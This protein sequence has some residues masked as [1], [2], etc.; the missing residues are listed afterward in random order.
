MNLHRFFMFPTKYNG[1]PPLP[2]F[3]S[4]KLNGIFAAYVPGRGFFTKKGV[5]WAPEVL[6]H[7]AQPPVGFPVVGEL[8][9]PEMSLQEI[10]SETSVIR[11]SSGGSRVQF[12][13]HDVM[14]QGIAADRVKT[15]TRLGE[16]KHENWG[17]LEHMLIKDIDDYNRHVQLFAALDAEGVVLLPAMSPYTPGKSGNSLAVKFWKTDNFAIVDYK[18]GVGKC[19]NVLA[20]LVCKTAS[21]ALFEVGTFRFPFEE[22]LRLLEQRPLPAKAEVRYLNL[23]DTGIPLNTSVIAIMEGE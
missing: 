22:R 8:Y 11:K 6:A 4:P 12:W 5:Q 9:H 19:E 17:F 14:T 23:S 21:G 20:A 3:L 16:E 13:P 7:I 10:I 15:L 18:S 1:K 2:V